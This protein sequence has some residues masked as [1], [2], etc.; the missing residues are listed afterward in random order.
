MSPLVRYASDL[1]FADL[2]LLFAQLGEFHPAS[3][4]GDLEN[5]LLRLE[6]FPRLA[7]RIIA[8]LEQGM[9]EHRLAPRIVMPRVVTQLRSLSN[10][11]AEESPLWAIISRLPADWSDT[12]RQAITDRIREGIVKHVVPAYSRLADFVEKTYMPA[13]PDRVGLS[14]TPDGAAHY[15]FLVRDYTTTDLT[16]DQIHETGL[17]E[18]A[19]TREAMESIRKQVGFEG[20]LKAFLAQMRSDPRHQN[21]SDTSI[22]DGHR[23]I[24]AT[25]EKQL[26]RLFGR[27]PRTPLE[28]RPFEADPRQ[29]VAGGRVLSRRFGRI[30]PWDL[31]REHV[32]ADPPPDLH[33]AGPGLS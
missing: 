28:V 5:Y 6:A 24:I 9:A 14:A 13:C 12:D 15:A 25:M 19:K 11:R 27:L 8:T 1:H 30:S 3:T 20:D 29:V 21:S 10:P 4:K 18:M 16:P 23:A 26:P 2:H 31:L 32:R 17:A 33:D 7:D 22:L